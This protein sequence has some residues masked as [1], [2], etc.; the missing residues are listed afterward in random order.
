MKIFGPIQPGRYFITDPCI[1]SNNPRNKYFALTFFKLT[2]DDGNYSDGLCAPSPSNPEE[3]TYRSNFR[4][5]P[6]TVSL[7]CVTLKDIDN[8]LLIQFHL[9]NGT[10]IEF[11]PNGKPYFGTMIV[12]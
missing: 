12:K 4:F 3:M 8:W 2:P 10:K 1:Y 5:H 6:G 11:L 7:G 9:L